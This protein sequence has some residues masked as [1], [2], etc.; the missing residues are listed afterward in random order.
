MASSPR[1]RRWCG[2]CGAALAAVV[3][4]AG[5]QDFIPA[6]HAEAHGTRYVETVHGSVVRNLTRHEFEVMRELR[7]FLMG[8]TIFVLVGA[9]LASGARRD[10]LG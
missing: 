5:P 2:G 4:A 6:G 7:F 9:M 10:A 8:S 1:V 3:L